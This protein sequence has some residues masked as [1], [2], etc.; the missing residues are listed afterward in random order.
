[1]SCA[2]PVGRGPSMKLTCAVTNIRLC[3]VNDV[4]GAAV[5]GLA[6]EYIPLCQ[7]YGVHFC[8]EVKPNGYAD[9]C[10]P[11]PLSQRWQRVAIQQAAGIARS[12]RSNH[13]HAQEDFAD[14]LAFWLE[15]EHRPEETS[16]LWIP[17]QTP[18][19]KQAVI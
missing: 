13:R 4:K 3:E 16:Q 5:G 12:W 19:I 7:Q 6:A 8:T 2:L 17:W 9:P 11:S 15:E 18:I 14:T 10:F 1:M